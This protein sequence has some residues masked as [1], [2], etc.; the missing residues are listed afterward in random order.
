M[1]KKSKRNKVKA[2][3]ERNNQKTMNRNDRAKAK[4]RSELAK[5]QSKSG[6]QKKITKVVA[7]VVAEKAR[8]EEIVLE[9]VK[10]G[11][12]TGNELRDDV[13]TKVADAA[14]GGGNG[15]EVLEAEVKAAEPG[16]ENETLEIE[17]GQIENVKALD[18]AD[19]MV[20]SDMSEGNETEK[21]TE[22][23][24]IVEPRESKEKI[25]LIGE[26]TVVR[27]LTGEEPL[28][29]NDVAR[30]DREIPEVKGGKKRRHYRMWIWWATGACSIVVLVIGG[31]A[32][33][34]LF[35][36]NTNVAD[37]GSGQMIVEE[38]PEMEEPEGPEEK[39]EEST[40]EKVEELPGT[41]E[42]KPEVIPEIAPRPEPVEDYPEVTVGHKVVAL[43]FDDGP[44]AATTPR[45]LDILGGRNVKATFFVLGTMARQ[46]PDILRREAAEGH[47]VASHTP[48]HTQ[49]TL[50]SAAQVRAEAL[51]MDQIFTDILGTVPPFT[52]PPYGSYNQMVQDAMG[53]PLILW[54]VDP[55]D[56]QY[57]DAAT[58]CNNVV[59]G[60]FDGAVIL[61]HDIHASTVDAVPCIIDTLKARGYEF[62]TVSELAAY[63]DVP[64][65]NGGVYGR[66]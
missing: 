59:S 44:S 51:E 4:T 37:E 27:G 17:E 28:G 58:V 48:Y 21:I 24:R 55:R 56:W 36:G 38:V 61:V 13:V 8:D 62:L 11:G 49:Q 41:T 23:P 45:L 39:P 15:D 50:L 1:S 66:F 35:K 30:V 29:S 60:T 53:Q 22:E 14:A 43:T 63:R 42:E 10:M 5:A 32:A 25:G 52:R 2:L 33:A 31:L 57:R 64:L 18:D 7:P 3:A 16:L 65:V 20:K 47:E 9:T 34:G 54:S 6:A 26:S 12:E 40:D 19:K 46:A